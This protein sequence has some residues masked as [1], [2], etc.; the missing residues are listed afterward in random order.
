MFVKDLRNDEVRSYK[1]AQKYFFK[2]IYFFKFFFRELMDY[3]R[4]LPNS[5]HLYVLAS[6]LKKN[7]LHGEMVIILF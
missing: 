5:D 4:N 6:N 2:F 7:Q 3:L 1:D